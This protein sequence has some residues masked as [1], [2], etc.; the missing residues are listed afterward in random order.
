MELRI[1]EIGNKTYKI[2][3]FTYI[4][5]VSFDCKRNL[6]SKSVYIFIEAFTFLVELLHSTFIIKFKSL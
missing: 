5:K 4:L 3:P 6:K 2:I 1:Y